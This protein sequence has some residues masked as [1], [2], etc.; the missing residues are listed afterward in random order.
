MKLWYYPNAALCVLGTIQ[1]CTVVYKIWTVTG[2]ASKQN[3]PASST[4]NFARKLKPLIVPIKFVV[5]F[6]VIWFA[7]FAVRW[8]VDTRYDRILDKVTVWGNCVFANFD[9]SNHWMKICGETP[10]ERVGPET[11]G[12]IMAAACSIATI[13]FL[14]FMVSGENFKR[15]SKAL[16]PGRIYALTTGR[17]AW[18]SEPVSYPSSSQAIS[19]ESSANGSSS[20]T[21]AASEALTAKDQAEI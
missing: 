20:P 14:I 13:T 4:S 17:S 1:M 16:H 5:L 19:G 6:L 2:S 18:V 7:L 21:A 9:G 8:Q 11:A 12:F 10:S 3:P 15:I